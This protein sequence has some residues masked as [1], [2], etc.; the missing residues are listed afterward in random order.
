M[1][2]IA[3]K[4]SKKGWEK[5]LANVTELEAMNEPTITRQHGESPIP[6]YTTTKLHNAR[7]REYPHSFKEG[8]KVTRACEKDVE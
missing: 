3:T 6:S 8:G 2:K 5:S 7:D 4:E 1:E